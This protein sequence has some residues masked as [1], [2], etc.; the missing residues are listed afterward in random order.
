MRRL[1]PSILHNDSH[2]SRENAVSMFDMISVDN[3]CGFQT[4]QR[5]MWATSFGRILLEADKV[6]N[7]YELVYHY[8]YLALTLR[9]R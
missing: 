6:G 8:D 9:L 5:K 1:T 3:P 7:G 2:N 4:S